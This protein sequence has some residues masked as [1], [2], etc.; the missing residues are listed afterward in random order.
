MH[1]AP[2]VSGGCR[3]LLFPPLS[4][5]AGVVGAGGAY[6]HV[7]IAGGIAEGRRRV[8]GHPEYLERED[9]QVVEDARHAFGYHAEILS[10]GEH[11]GGGYD[12]WKLAQGRFPPELIVPFVEEMV[13]DAVEGCLLLLGK[14]SV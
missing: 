6:A 8:L 12:L 5:G 7:G 4:Q 1:H 2:P 3:T 11:I 9:S 14:V 13:V 10:A